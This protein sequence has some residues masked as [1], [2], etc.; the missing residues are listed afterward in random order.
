MQGPMLKAEEQMELVV[1]RKHGASIGDCRD[2]RAGRG[3]IGEAGE[4]PRVHLNANKLL[5]LF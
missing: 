1:F 3:T 4:E 2:R 5:Q